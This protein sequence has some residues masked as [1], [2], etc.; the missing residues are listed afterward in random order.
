MLWF[1]IFLYQSFSSATN[2][3]QH[4]CRHLPNMKMVVLFVH[5]LSFV[6]KVFLIFLFFFSILYMFWFWKWTVLSNYKEFYSS[7]WK[8]NRFLPSWKFSFLALSHLFR[9]LFSYV[10]VRCF[11]NRIERYKKMVLNI[12]AVVRL[13]RYRRLIL[14]SILYQTAN[15]YVYPLIR[16]MWWATYTFL[17]SILDSYSTI[18]SFLQ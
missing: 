15:Q 4:S 13:F 9:I 7:N 1:H 18:K 11:Q 3:L 14:E 12:I 16:S 6:L 17:I 5:F 10:Y 8:I 2:N